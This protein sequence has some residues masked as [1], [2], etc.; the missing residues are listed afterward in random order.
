MPHAAIRFL[1]AALAALA[2]APAPSRAQE[3]AAGAEPAAEQPA[4]ID[5]TNPACQPVYPAASLKAGVTGTTKVRF[6]VTA[7]GQITS[8]EIVRPSGP[9]LEHRLLDYA[10]QQALTTCP[11]IPGHDWKGRVVG[12]TIN[13]EHVWEL[14][15]SSAR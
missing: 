8:A 10:F 2:L 9:T 13:A 1:S 12:G 14:P 5:S 7:A 6:V 11:Y 3:S 15:A 4:R